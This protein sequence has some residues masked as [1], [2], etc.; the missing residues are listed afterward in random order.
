MLL[1]A[2]VVTIIPVQYTGTAVI[3]A[4]QTS[5]TSL[6]M[7]LGQL[8]GGASNSLTSILPEGIDSGFR[9]PGETY[10]GILSSRS[11]ADDLISK[12]KLVQLYHCKTLVD[13]RKKLA[14][15]TRIEITKGSLIRI[16]VDDHSAQRAADM[17]NYYVDVLYHI[18]EHL[19]L[20]QASQRR[21]F[22]ENQ[23]MTESDALAKAEIEFKQAQE[24][25]GVIQLSGQAELT[26]R[27]IAQL[28]GELVS[29]E[30]QLQQLRTVATENNETVSNLETSIA[31]IR[32][33]LEKAEKGGSD[34]DI[35]DYFLPAGRVPT[36]ELEY[37]RKV[38]QLKYH[39]ALYEMLSKQYQ[40]ARLDE[41]KSPPLIQ[42]VDRAIVLD[43]RS[44]PPRTLLVLLSGL[45][46]L[47][48]ACMFVLADDA[49]HKLALH[50]ANA[51][52]IT[53]LK[54]MWNKPGN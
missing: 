15:H 11:V 12:F 24:A 42:V 1:T 7:I 14:R 25:T 22:L 36:A 3:L 13:T 53:M 29:R 21:V 41:A 23:V 51:E 40:V 26:L 9:T 37:I 28:R 45:M 49:W 10:I 17:A 16:V 32:N 44:W 20:T 35:A 47:T 8:G 33:Q 2:V 48:F 27:T 19:A 46:S 54:A 34:S 30:L 5:S 31:A 38:R 50:P 18:N 4:P 39:E 43:K 6:S 52:Q